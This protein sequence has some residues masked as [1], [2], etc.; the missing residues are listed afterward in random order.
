MCLTCFADSTKDYSGYKTYVSLGDSIADGI[1]LPDN[2]LRGAAQTDKT[3]VYCGKTPG[4]YPVLIAEALGIEDDNF[5]QLACA[6]MRTVELRACIDPDYVIPDQYANNFQGDELCQW[7]QSR[8]DYVKLLSDADIVTMNMC[9]NDVASYA[10]FYVREAMAANGVSESQI[11]SLV[12]ESEAS[13]QYFEAVAVLLEYAEAAEYYAGI[14]K[15]AIE[16]LSVGYTHWTENWDAICGKIYELNPDV[17]LV[18]IGMYNPFKDMKLTQDSLIE[19]GAAIDG[20]VAAINTWSAAGSAY[21]D[22]YIYVDILSIE[23][24]LATTGKALTDEGALDNFELNVHPSVKGH[25]QIADKVM[26]AVPEK[27][28]DGG[29]PASEPVNPIQQVAEKH[30]GKLFSTAKYAVADTCRTVTKFIAKLT[31]WF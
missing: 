5:S 11:D 27:S 21:A 13:G 15:A 23:S 19:I 3:L 31:T 9:A 1:G 2:A 29:T 16:G 24:M 28:A 22:K 10:L 20:I 4:A 26:K 17:T 8:F 25:Q 30:A 18:C 7:V 12:A 14:V 6:G